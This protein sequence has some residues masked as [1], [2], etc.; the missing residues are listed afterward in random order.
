MS[1][2]PIG[3]NMTGAYKYFLCRLSVFFVYRLSIVFN[4]VG[5]ASEI[6]RNKHF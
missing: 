1:E 3:I 4:V 2:L 5:V 6:Y